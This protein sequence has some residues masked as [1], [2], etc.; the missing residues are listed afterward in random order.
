[1]DAQPDFELEP[2]W[3]GRPA[4]TGALAR[5]RR[6]RL[7]GAAMSSSRRVLA[8]GLAR[9]VEL[10]ALTGTRGGP[11]TGAGACGSVCVRA[12]DGLG[13]VETARGLLVHRVRISDGL[14]DDYRVLAPTEWNFHPRGPMAAAVSGIAA[15]SDEALH[16]A[17]GLAVQSL[18]PCVTCRIEVGHA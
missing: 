8:R 15:A 2:Q 16:D 9:M 14:I 6:H 18:D 11:A 13:W 4:E 17:I 3:R 1:M 7:V 10:A 5:C 12:G